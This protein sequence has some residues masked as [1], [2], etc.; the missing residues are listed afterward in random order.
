MNRSKAWLFRVSVLY[1]LVYCIVGVGCAPRG[2]RFYSGMP[3]PN[4]EVALVYTCTYCIIND[5]ND[6]KDDKALFLIQMLE[7]LPGRYNMG[8]TYNDTYRKGSR[9]QIE[10]NAQAG[11]IYAIYPFF[12]SEQMQTWNAVLVNM[13]N[14]SEEKCNSEKISFLGNRTD[15]PSK[16][17]IVKKASSYLNGERPVMI[18]RP[19]TKPVVMDY[20]DAKHTYNGIWG[21]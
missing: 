18:F 1:L 10:L 7:L 4:N 8:I 16:D 2:G 9:I 12:K 11:N 13:G 5:I 6:A 17:S 20:G 14:Y 15:C 19:F 3:L 21:P